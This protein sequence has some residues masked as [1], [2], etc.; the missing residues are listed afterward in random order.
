MVAQDAIS[1]EAMCAELM[2]SYVTNEIV[3]EA[4]S[5]LHEQK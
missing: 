5:S 3:K 2:E 1:S 4:K